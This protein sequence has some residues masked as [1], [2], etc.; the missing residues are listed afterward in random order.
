MVQDFALEIR[1]TPTSCPTVVPIGNVLDFCCCVQREKKIQPSLSLCRFYSSC[2]PFRLCRVVSRPASCPATSAN[3]SDWMGEA[4]SHRR[5]RLSGLR[6]LRPVGEVMRFD[7]K[8]FSL[9]AL[10]IVSTLAVL[11]CGYAQWWPA[12]QLLI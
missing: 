8:R 4:M 1:A 12:P 7:K 5:F 11:F 6:G 9:R 2:H 3:H 10:F